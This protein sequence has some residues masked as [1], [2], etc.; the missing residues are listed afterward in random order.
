MKTICFFLI[1]L[2]LVFPFFL[3]ETAQSAELTILDNTVLVKTDTYEVQFENGVITHLYNKLTEETYTLP[4]GIGGHSGLLRRNEGHVWTRDATLIFARKVT[5]LKAEIVFRQGQSEFRLFIGVDARSGDLLIE[6]E[7][8]SDTA[9]I[10]GI[11]WGCGNLNV[12]NLDL[13]LP[14]EGGQIIDAMSP[15]TSR[16]FNY[17]GSWEVQLAILQGEQGGF[18]VRGADET[19]QFKALH[20]E[21]DIDS[22]A[23]NFETQNQAPFDTLTSAKSVVWRL[24]TY[25]G[26]W[27]VPA[28][29]YQEWMEQAFKPWRLDEMPTWVQDI[30]LV[31]IYFGLDSRVLEKLAEQT[32]PTKTLLYVV[33]WRKDDFDENI[34]DYTAKPEFGNFVEAAHQHGFRVM[35]HTNLVGVSEYHPLYADLQKFQFRNPWNGDLEGWRW[36]EIEIPNRHAWISPASSKFRKLFVEQLKRVW[37]EYRVD[38]FY[39][40]I[41]HAVVNDA[42]GLIEGLNAGQGNVLL[43][44]E[45]A[46]AMPGVV[47]GGESLH[48]VTFLRESFAQRWKLPPEWDPSPRGQPHPISAFLFSPYTLPYGYFSVA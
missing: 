36:A 26:D 2:F 32:D 1:I 42:N 20:Y 35:P 14:A 40:D 12:R 11:Q 41:S 33:D 25:S 27:R 24:N 43:H 28:R 16:S 44:K 4:F 8:T 31:V 21:K 39:L 48:E 15:V 45:L 30:G 37:Q 17:P 5:P 9:G 22:F 47:F 46:S 23:L 19:F 38:A 3:S 10:Y 7:G 6:Q 29:Q 34:P 18:F 13:I